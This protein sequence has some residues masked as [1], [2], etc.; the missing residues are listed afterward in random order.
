MFAAAEEEEVHHV[1]EQE[2]TQEDAWVVIRCVLAPYAAF[3]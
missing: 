1:D 3:R 2:I